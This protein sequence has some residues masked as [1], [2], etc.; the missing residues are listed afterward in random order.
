MQRPPSTLPTRRANPQP[1][2]S[3]NSF[4][5]CDFDS[6][7]VSLFESTAKCFVSQVVMFF[8]CYN[9][10][11]PAYENIRQLGDGLRDRFS[12]ID[13]AGYGWILEC[14]THISIV[15]KAPWI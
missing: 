9:N 11:G 1:F 6:L 14:R 7:S 5:M 3:G 15:G 2:P 10:R 4:G 13:H 8:A 12:C